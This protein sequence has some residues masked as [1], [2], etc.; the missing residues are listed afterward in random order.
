MTGLEVIDES[1]WSDVEFI[2]KN[3]PVLAAYSIC[4]TLAE[5]T[6]FEFAEKHDIE[7]VSVIPPWIHGPFVTPH[8][9]GSVR[10]LM[11]Y[12]FGERDLMIEHYPTIPVVH[13][14][15]VANA[16][17]FLFEYPNA[18]GRYICSNVAIT[19]NQ[20]TRLLSARYPEY[21][22]PIVE[23]SKEVCD[24]Q[25]PEYSSKKLLETGFKYEHGLEVM[26]DGAIECCKIR[27]LF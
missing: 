5:K 14:D 26:Y 1:S 19:I 6:A 12:F 2:R 13:V 11:G 20:L 15:D 18:R 4:K 7:V 21:K 3:C 10:D 17:I 8:C 16:H 23:L 9:P 24:S 25:Y 22:I 27:G